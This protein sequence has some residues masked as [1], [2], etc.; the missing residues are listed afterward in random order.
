M[1]TILVTGGCGFIGSTFIDLVLRDKRVNKVINIDKVTYCADEKA[2]KNFKNYKLIKD[3]INN[4][5][6]A[7]KGKEKTIDYIFHFA[8][9]SHVDNSISGPEPFV[10][11]NVNG[12]F[13]MVEFAKAFDIPIVVVS[14]DEV[15]GSLNYDAKSSIETDILKPSSVYS[16]TKASADLIALSY[17][18]TFK[19]NVKITRCCNNYGINQYEEKFLPTVI[20]NLRAGKKIPVYGDGKNI[21]EWI[22]AKDHCE[23]VW[24]VATL[25]E[26]GEIYNIGTSDE[27][28]N[29]E[30]VRLFLEKWGLDES[31]IEYVEDR[32]GHDLR[33]S[34]N[35]CK[36]TTELGWFPKS[37]NIEE[38]IDF[39]VENFK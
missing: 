9:E 3:D 5:F 32:K 17:F 34:L 36:I 27:R 19:T 20:R 39:V 4:V 33:Y 26:P 37:T 31:S 23:A 15:Y 35:C 1:D 29:I 38:F 18:H 22:N 7:L 21:R 14:T 16:S 30:I 12:T 10:H 24:A 8:A 6:E 28:S 2:N 25:G 13:K 11:S